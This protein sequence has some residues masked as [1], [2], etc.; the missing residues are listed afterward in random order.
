MTQY[1]DR[2]EIQMPDQLGSVGDEVSVGVAVGM[3]AVTVTPLIGC[4]DARPR[5][6]VAAES[7]KIGTT[8][9]SAVQHD[10]RTPGSGEVDKRYIDAIYCC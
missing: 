8:S 10:D 5:R 1:H 3:A 7:G 2:A 6:E 4:D 9:E